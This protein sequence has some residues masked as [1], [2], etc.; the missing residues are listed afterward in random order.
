M[1]IKTNGFEGNAPFTSNVCD[2]ETSCG[3][4]VARRSSRMSDDNILSDQ[5]N[6]SQH[7]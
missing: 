3:L 1:R 5:I 4:D 7:T 2:L 6:L